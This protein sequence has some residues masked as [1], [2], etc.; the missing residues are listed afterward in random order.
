MSVQLSNL[1]LFVNCG[2]VE[3]LLDREKKLDCGS[4]TLTSRTGQK[5]LFLVSDPIC[6]HFLAKVVEQLKAEQ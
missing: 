2:V 3:K 6:M 5:A 4:G 1:K